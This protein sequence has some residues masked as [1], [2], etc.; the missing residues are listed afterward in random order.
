[1][2]GKKR[3]RRSGEKIKLGKKRPPNNILGTETKVNPV[4]DTSVKDESKP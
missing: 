4:E 3:K 2:E 1:M